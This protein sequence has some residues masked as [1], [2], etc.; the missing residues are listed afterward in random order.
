M[1]TSV[2]PFA[3]A[4]HNLAEIV[5][6]FL[7]GIQTGNTQGDAGRSEMKY[8]TAGELRA[9]MV[10][11]FGHIFNFRGDYDSATPDNS[12]V[13]DLFLC[14]GTFTEGSKTYTE[15]QFYAYSIEQEWEDV[16]TGLK[17]P[18]G[19]TGEA[20]GF[21]TPSVT[22]DANVGTP[23]VEIIAT[24]PDTAKIFSFIFR[25]LKG[26]KGDTGEPFAI[27]KTYAS[28]AEMN[29]DF[30]N[31][32]EGKFVIIASGTQDPDNAKL[33][34]RGASEFTY[35]TDLSGA[36]GIQG[37]EGP[38]GETGATGNGISSIVCRY[39]VTTT[40]TQPDP[41][42][43]TGT[44]IPVMSST[45]KYLWQKAVISYTSGSTETFVTLA[46]IYGDTG[47]T[48]PQGPEGPEGASVSIASQ[49]VQYQVSESGTV[50]PT[51]EWL[52]TVPEVPSGQ[53]MWTRVT[54]TFSPSGGHTSYSVAYQG[55]DDISALEDAVEELEDNVGE[56]DWQK[57]APSQDIS[58]Q[59]EQL[60]EDVDET[61]TTAVGDMKYGIIAPE[62]IE[63][64]RVVSVPSSSSDSGTA[65]DVSFDSEHFYICISDNVWKAVSL[66]DF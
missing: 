30:D 9:Y 58:E 36:Q 53:F 37:P 38:Q 63:S 6:S 66:T 26:V 19:D 15:G 64:L 27:Y 48:G 28:I 5:D 51:G 44:T 34:V 16:T 32:P 46:A 2:V 8:V 11:Y 10:K 1:A 55:R 4:P 60:R 62:T 20:A 41:A 23:S 47:A 65:G 43:I 52:D 17:G 56:L 13:N 40:Q 42:D 57:E 49:S 39:A 3:N 35:I 54:V 45:D 61:V 24:G 59:M 33:Y 12:A 7:L 29:A 18:K 21:G 22:I 14:S 31:V 50:V 25:N